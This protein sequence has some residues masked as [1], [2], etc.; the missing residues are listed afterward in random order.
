MTKVFEF[1]IPETL[2]HLLFAW[3]TDLLHP[4]SSI[5]H[6]ASRDQEPVPIYVISPSRYQRKKEIDWSHS[7]CHVSNNFSLL[8]TRLSPVS[9]SGKRN[10]FMTTGIIKCLTTYPAAHSVLW[11]YTH[12]QMLYSKIFIIS[13]NWQFVRCCPISQPL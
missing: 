1:G 5:Q 4:V 2:N 12:N 6:R 9:K 3:T 13:T 7:G 11:A 8:H 10:I